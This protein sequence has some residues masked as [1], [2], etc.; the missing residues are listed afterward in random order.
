[1]AVKFDDFDTEKYVLA[2]CLQGPQIWQEF[3]ESWLRNDM[4]RKAIKEFKKFF[5]PP[6]STYPS[7]SMIIE[8]CEDVDIKLF[9][10]EISKIKIDKRDFRVKLYD[11]W[12]MYA[13]KMVYDVADSIPNDLEKN[14][15]EEVVKAKIMELSKLV[16]PFEA[17]QRKRGFIYEGAKAKWSRYREVEKNPDL[18]KRTPLLISE[19]DKYLHGG[20]KPGWLVL[21]YAESGGLKTKTMANLA[22]NLSHLQKE[23]TA[24]I[25]LEVPFEDYE[26]IIESRNA[27]LDFNSIQQGELGDRRDDYKKSLVTIA[28]TKPPLYLI[29]IP[30]EATSADLVAESELFYSI[31]GHY[32]KWLFLDYANEMDPITPWRSTGEKYKNLGVEFRRAVRSYRYGFFTAMQENRKGKETKDKAKVGTEHIGESHSFQNPFHVIIHQ[33]Q[34]SE[35]IDSAASQLHMSIKKNRYGEKNV[36][37]SVFASPAYNYIG[38]RKINYSGEL[39]S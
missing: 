16:N 38:D 10:T 36:S 33:Y 8:K 4:S 31:H 1:M 12:E 5:Q 11:L 14:R 7:A 29:D 37:F 28:E 20:V 3:P 27:L 6:Y 15:I 32:P 17:G 22:Y 21:F 34:D 39:E 35:G 26:D 25:T 23:E 30:G 9:V 18:L 24:V 19:L 13:A 2:G